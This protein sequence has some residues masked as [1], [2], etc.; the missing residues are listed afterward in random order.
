MTHVSGFF[1]THLFFISLFSCLILGPYIY[2]WNWLPRSVAGW[3]NDWLAGWLADQSNQHMDWFAEIFRPFIFCQLFWIYAL[4]RILNYNFYM[5]I[6]SSCHVDLSVSKS[7]N[8]ASFHF[9]TWEV[10]RVIMVHWSFIIP[11]S[12]HGS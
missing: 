5:S 9:M 6:D 1:F 11:C 4:L 7:S 3:L 10:I 2:W 8:V 12:G